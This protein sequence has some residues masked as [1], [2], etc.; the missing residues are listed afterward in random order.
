MAVFQ[1][2]KII[3][4]KKGQGTVEYILL[5]ALISSLVFVVFKSS[6]FKTLFQSDAGVFSTMRKGMAYTYRYGRE[7]KDTAEYDT[8][9]SFEYSNAQ[10]PLYFNKQSNASR[11]FSGTEKYGE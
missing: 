10:H 8:A 9:M 4:N 5:L 2:Y 1:I 11:F 3:N 6:K 7:Y